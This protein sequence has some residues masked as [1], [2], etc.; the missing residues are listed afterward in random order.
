MPILPKFSL[1]EGRDSRIPSLYRLT[2]AGPREAGPAALAA[3]DPCEKVPAPAPE[4]NSPNSPNFR[5]VSS[6]SFQ[7]GCD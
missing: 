4:L 3:E 1:L 5:G 6:L 7:F 2:G